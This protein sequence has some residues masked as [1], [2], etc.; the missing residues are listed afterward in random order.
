M[1][2]LN[3]YV[4]QTLKIYNNVDSIMIVDADTVICYYYTAY[5]MVS[6][7]SGSE[8]LGRKLLDAYPYLTEDTSFI[9]QCLKTGKSY[10]NYEQSF[11]SYL[12]K[13]LRTISSAVPIH[14]GGK[15]VAVAD[16]SVYPNKPVDKNDLSIEIDTNLVSRQRDYELE[17]IITQSPQ[18]ND[19]KDK[20]LMSHDSDAP[21][22]VYGKTG[23]GKEMVVNAIHKCSPRRG[24]PLITQNCAAIPSTLLESILFG[25]TK[26]S[27]T[28]ANDSPGLFEMADGGTLFL[29]EIN[30]MELE[31]QAKILRAIE[32]NKIRRI[33]DKR[34]RKVDVR[35]IAAMNEDPE[36]CLKQHRIRE[37]LYYRLSV[38][39]YD[40]PELA[41]RKE[42]I[43]LLMEHFRNVFNCRLGKNI[44]EYSR[45]VTRLFQDYSWPGN[46]RE[47]KNVIEAAY[48][49]NYGSI[50]DVDNIPR[51]FLSHMG[52]DK[53]VIQDTSGRSLDELVQEFERKLIE[54]KY[55]ENDFKL[56]Q[57]ARALQLSKQSLWYKMKKY[58]IVRDTDEE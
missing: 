1:K 39:R 22:L 32:E 55:Q 52:Q 44:L 12:G 19:I 53:V 49:S 18:M 46:V 50:I 13:T 27:F 58:N 21:V 28:G 11:T 4:E 14:D 57:T 15:L 40:L 26:G 33:G 24:G 16:I 45:E 23:T 48:H 51:H 29:D 25:T 10:M 6:G 47:L 8:V 20:I 35:I 54:S 9:L 34:E 17:D 41:K 3:R 37:D 2:N 43:P 30:S 56:S 31:A 7:L 38:I 5:P 36:T 42:D